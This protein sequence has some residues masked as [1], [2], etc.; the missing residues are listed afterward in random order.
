MNRWMLL[1]AACLLAASLVPARMGGAQDDQNDSDEVQAATEIVAALSTLNTYDSYQVTVTEFTELDYRLFPA[2]EGQNDN[3]GE[4]VSITTTSTFAVDRDAVTVQGNVDTLIEGDLLFG[5][6]L[7]GVTNVVVG[8][9]RV[10]DGEIYLQATADGLDP[11]QPV[12]PD[13]WALLSEGMPDF[14][15][16][17]AFSLGNVYGF[18]MGEQHN[19]TPIGDV[20]TTILQSPDDIV[21]RAEEIRVQGGRATGEDGGRITFYRVLGDGLAD[22]VAHTAPIPIPDSAALTVV[23]DG[24]SDVSLAVVVNDNGQLITRIINYNIALV[25]VDATIFGLEAG[26]MTLRAA[27]NIVEEYSAINDPVAPIQQPQLANSSA[28]E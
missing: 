25:D 15:G 19:P 11:S 6:R 23:I 13:G 18:S 5:A 1:F 26:E 20:P 21:L 14:V 10:V 3:R 9:V 12:P 4:L 17:R 27:V 2:G 16:I 8:E 7:V 22:V 28:T 24:I